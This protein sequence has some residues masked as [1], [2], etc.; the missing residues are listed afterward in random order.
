MSK[1]IKKV[2]I[3]QKICIVCN[4][5]FTWRKKW[6]KF[7]DDVKYCSHKCKKNKKLLTK[8]KDVM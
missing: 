5:L 4:R 3:P 1:N 6:K 7:W 8:I 2:H